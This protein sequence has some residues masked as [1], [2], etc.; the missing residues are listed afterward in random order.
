M[1]RLS[2]LQ[3]PE[4]K[5]FAE[6]KP[7]L[8]IEEAQ[9][10]DQRAFRSMLLRDYVSYRPGRGFHITDTGLKAWDDFRFHAYLRKNPTLPLTAYFDATAYG[11][12][13]VARVHVMKRRGAA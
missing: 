4:L 3:Y 2:A 1:T 7:H 10:L 5:L 8:S 6:G 11:L 9:K 12:K 13:P